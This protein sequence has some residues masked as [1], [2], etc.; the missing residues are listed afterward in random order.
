ML[1]AHPGVHRKVL[2]KR[3]VNLI[4]AEEGEELATAL[5]VLPQQGG[6]VRHFEGNA[7]AVWAEC[8]EKLPPEPVR[9][10]LNAA[11][12]TAYKLQPA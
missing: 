6:M 7:A 8:L 11:V 5:H 10:D 9:F 3:V 4:A 12:D 1:D 2:V